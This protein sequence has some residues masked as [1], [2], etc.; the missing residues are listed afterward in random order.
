M[1]A[2]YFD[3]LRLKMQEHRVWFGTRESGLAILWDF[4]LAIGFGLLEV[5]ISIR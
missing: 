5:G 2:N 4:L 3:V 1:G